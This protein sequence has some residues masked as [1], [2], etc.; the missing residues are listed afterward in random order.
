MMYSSSD[1]RSLGAGGV[2]SLSE[3][4]DAK[5]AAIESKDYAAAR[6]IKE[7]IAALVAASGSLS[8]GYTEAAS[9]ADDP[10]APLLATPVMVDRRNSLTAIERRPSVQQLYGSDIKQL[11]GEMVPLA[12]MDKKAVQKPWNAKGK[13]ETAY[14]MKMKNFETPG[15]T[16]ALYQVNKCVGSWRAK[17]TTKNV[18]YTQTNYGPIPSD[19][20]ARTLET[21]RE[22]QRMFDVQQGA[23]DTEDD[24]GTLLRDGEVVLDTLRCIGFIGFPSHD[25]EQ[26]TVT[27][28][29]K[30]VLTEYTKPE[31]ANV[32]RKYAQVE[33]MHRILMICKGNPVKKVDV[34]E[35]EV[36]P[37]GCC[38]RGG[39]NVAKGDY[40]ADR[41][42]N[43][44]FAAMGVEDQLVDIQTEQMER[45]HLTKKQEFPLKS[46]CVNWW[47]IVI[48]VLVFVVLLAL[49]STGA[50]VRDLEYLLW[51]GVGGLCL[52][53]VALISY[54][55]GKQCMDLCRDKSLS[56]KFFAETHQKDLKA[57]M[58]VRSKHVYN[59][60]LDGRRIEGRLADEK[61]WKGWTAELHKMSYNALYMQFNDT[62]S[63]E[64]REMIAVVDAESIAT[65]LEG[66][67]RSDPTRFASLA[68]AWRAHA[69][70]PRGGVADRSL[71]DSMSMNGG[72]GTNVLSKLLK[73]TPAPATTSSGKGFLSGVGGFFSGFLSFIRRNLCCL[74]CLGAAGGAGYGIY[75]AITQ[76][77]NLPF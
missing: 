68:H 5:R 48:G 73:G 26:Q 32:H 46:K 2:A 16:N 76:G 22:L 28:K 58:E 31:I 38:G 33:V 57:M 51:V 74:I 10:K 6:Q 75:Y 1:E 24:V 65:A 9:G 18:T 62:C 40:E 47:P 4:E 70:K 30:L 66:G 50:S 69:A 49:T 17:P 43:N 7:D 3:L 55:W 53:F 12:R 13:L 35:Y 56:F 61:T 60:Y 59:T 54:W 64:L 36:Q 52:N 71:K 44:C 8:P 11:N 72:G 27:G 67:D 21:D 34:T 19:N 15:E 20:I 23:M 77:N 37:R 63:H 42:Q 25:A 41:E 14:M 29:C 45:L 39:K